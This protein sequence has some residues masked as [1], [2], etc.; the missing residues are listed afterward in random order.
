MFNVFYKVVGAKNGLFHSE[1][2]DADY[3]Q[4]VVD[5]G[6]KLHA[7]ERKYFMR[8]VEEEEKDERFSWVKTDVDDFRMIANFKD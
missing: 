1:H 7:G 2:S 5:A 3:A 8:E 6:N 4:V